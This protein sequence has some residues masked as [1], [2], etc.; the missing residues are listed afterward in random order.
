[1]RI[2]EILEITSAVTSAMFGIRDHTVEVEFCVHDAN[3]WGSDILEG[4][5]AVTTDCHSDATG[6]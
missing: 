5:K 2:E 3:S 4:I 1:L 6:I